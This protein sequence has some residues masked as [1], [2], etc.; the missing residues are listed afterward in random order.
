MNESLIE[1][2]SRFTRADLENNEIFQGTWYHSIELLP[3]LFTKGNDFRNIRLT[4]EMLKGCELENMNCLDVGAQDC[5][6]AILMKRRGASS[7]TAQ[8]IISRRKQVELLK[9]ILQLDFNYISRTRLSKLRGITKTLGLHPFD[10]V[11]FSGVLYHMF[12]PL[13]GL[14]L[15]RGMV[16]NGGLLVIE[17]S[18]IID[19]SM[20]AYFNAS[21]RF[22]PH[23]NYWEV[24]V[25]CL[26]YLLRFLRL[27]PLDCVYFNHPRSKTAS[28]PI[29]RIAVTCRAM[30]DSLPCKDDTW[31]ANPRSLHY[32]EFLEWKELE[33]NPTHEVK[34]T[35]QNNRLIYREDTRTVDLYETV[36]AS[37]E[38]TVDNIDEQVRLRLDAMF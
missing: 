27:A 15:V 9:K 7:V 37:P 20:V 24:S 6:I 5:L 35:T 33:I 38:T 10:V 25:E 32:A 4:R 22:G 14:A 12:D 17:T 18:A 3:G 19:N 36:Q 16:R 21:G 11:V 23:T 31:M 1:S 8:D 26:D 30:E 28:L 2:K 29:C 34:Y 13:R